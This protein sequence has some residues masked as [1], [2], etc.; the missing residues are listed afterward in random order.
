MNDRNLSKDE[1]TTSL[2][3]QTRKN[4]KEGT[5]GTRK[6]S[7]YR[8]GG[9][10]PHKTKSGRMRKLSKRRN[11]PQHRDSKEHKG[12]ERLRSRPSQIINPKK[13]QQIRLETDF[14]LSGEI[15]IYSK[16]DNG[17]IQGSLQFEKGTLGLR[18]IGVQVG[19]PTNGYSTDSR[20]I[21]QKI[22]TA[23]GDN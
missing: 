11:N 9:S 1:P 12:R 7:K 23:G 16:E 8:T 17:G 15:K 21:R 6:I 20:R 10:Q 5:N 22:D 3:P 4:P 2:I 18:Y 14:S 13:N 19:I